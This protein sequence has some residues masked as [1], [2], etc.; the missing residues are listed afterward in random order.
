MNKIN[1]KIIPPVNIV[2]RHL[3]LM[4][5]SLD[6]K[7]IMTNF[8]RNR[9]IIY[10]G[11]T[12]G[13]SCSGSRLAKL[14]IHRIKLRSWFVCTRWS[15]VNLEKI[16]LYPISNLSLI[17]ISIFEILPLTLDGIDAQMNF[18][19]LYWLP[20]NF[21][22]F[23]TWIRAIFSHSLITYNSPTAGTAAI[24]TFVIFLHF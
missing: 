22:Y 24:L 13:W 16:L 11:I 6:S 20:W 21:E 2:Q 17:V 10:C 19:I 12:K 4:R 18:C 1:I 15:L 3:L 23:R 5:L 14:V 8:I 9:V 7:Y